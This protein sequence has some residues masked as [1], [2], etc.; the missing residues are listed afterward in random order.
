MKVN[1][2][3]ILQSILDFFLA[4]GSIF[5][6]V[7]KEPPEDEEMSLDEI[8]LDKHFGAAWKYIEDATNRYAVDN[9]DD[10]DVDALRDIL[11][12]K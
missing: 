1:I 9:M 8:G 6:L 12:N 10:P 7:P 5:S 2:Q 3:K 11:K 4:F